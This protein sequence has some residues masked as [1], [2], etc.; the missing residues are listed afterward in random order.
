MDIKQSKED[1]QKRQE[2]LAKEFNEIIAEERVLAQRKAQ[3][4]QEITMNNGEARMLN[5]LN[6]DSPSK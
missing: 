5:R 3:V 6:G 4:I 1:L 2:N